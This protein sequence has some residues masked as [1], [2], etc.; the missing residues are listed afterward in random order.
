MI[1]YD[2][3][4]E[5]KKLERG[6]S[7][8]FEID[9]HRVFEWASLLSSIHNHI[10]EGRMFIAGSSLNALIERLYEAERELEVWEKREKDAVDKS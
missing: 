5:L 1:M 4:E 2:E 10:V 8:R 6:F 3:A 7:Y 9:S